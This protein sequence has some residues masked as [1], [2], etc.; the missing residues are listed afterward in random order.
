MYREY[1]GKLFLEQKKKK[2]IQIVLSLR[3]IM[4]DLSG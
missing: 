2:E 4:A 1:Q 3:A